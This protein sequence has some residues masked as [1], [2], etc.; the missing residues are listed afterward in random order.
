MF[1]PFPLLRLPFLPFEKVIKGMSPFQILLLSLC[2]KRSKSKCQL[3]KPAKLLFLK[4]Y[5]GAKARI[6]VMFENLK[7]K[8]QV[9]TDCRFIAHDFYW[10]H[11]TR[12]LPDHWNLINCVSKPSSD[13]EFLKWVD[14]IREVYSTS[15]NIFVVERPCNEEVIEWIE[16]KKPSIDVL[17]FKCHTPLIT[18]QRI[19][20]CV[21]LKKEVNIRCGVSPQISISGPSEINELTHVTNSMNFSDLLKLKCPIIRSE[22]TDFSDTD[23]NIFL[24]NWKKNGGTF[25]E[26]TVNRSPNSL[27]IDENVV[28]EGLDAESIEYSRYEKPADQNMKVFQ[29][30]SIRNNQEEIAVFGFYGWHNKN[31]KFKFFVSTSG[32]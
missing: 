24:K 13:K 16:K 8:F 10:Y 7:Q 29:G 25:D 28:I 23:L 19:L 31:V 27:D 12:W 30:Y 20:N 15:L 3:M 4:V 14:T 2:S 6:T 22:C 17:F 21:E 26:L 18:M 9:D 1:V 32:L 11:R 5:L